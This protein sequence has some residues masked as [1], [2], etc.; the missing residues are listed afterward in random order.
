MIALGETLSVSAKVLDNQKRYI[1]LQ[2][3]NYAI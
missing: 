2:V 1:F 3:K